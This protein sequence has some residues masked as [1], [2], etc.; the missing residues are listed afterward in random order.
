MGG[1]RKALIIANDTYEQDA[2]SNL[3]APASDAEALGR[4]LGN[5]QIGDF[6]VQVVQNEPRHVI[7]AQIEDLFS[8]SRPDDVLLMHFSGHGLKSESGDLFFA[9]C[10]TRPNRLRATAVSAD[11]VQQCMR[12]SRSRSIVLLLDCCYAGAFTQGVRARAAGAVNVF[13]S[14]PQAGG[15]GRAVITASNAIEYAFEGDRLA[16]DQHGRPS[17]FTGALVEGLAT[18]DADQDEDGWVSLNE[19]YDYV[20]DKVRDQNPQQTPSRQ[21]ELEGE[22]YL[23]RSQRRRIHPAAI[24]PE[25][26]AALTDAN[27]FARLGAVGE[28]RVRLASDNL[29]VA[30]GAYEALAE[31][32]RTDIRF[33]ADPAAKALSEASVQPA[34]TELHFGRAEHGSAPPHQIVHLLGPPIARACAP[35]PSHD[36]IRVDQVAEGLDI[37][38]DT[39]AT[40]TLHGSLDLKGPTGEAVI[41]I[42]AEIVSAPPEPA[43][44]RLSPTGR[45][46]VPDAGALQPEAPHSENAPLATAP[47]APPTAPSS[48]P[49]PIRRGVAF[50]GAGI[51][52]LAGVAWL[53]SV[54]LAD[55]KGDS[56][57]YLFFIQ[58]SNVVPIAV[59]LIALLRIN[60]LVILGLLQGMWWIAASALIGDPVNA[61]V[62][63]MSGDTGRALT[64]D[65]VGIIGDV[66]GVCAVILLVISWNQAAG[67]RHAWKFRM[68]PVMLVCGVGL[69]QI[70]QFIF[71]YTD[72]YS[73]TNTA[74]YIAAILVGLA[75]AWYATRLRAS[76]LGGALVLG[77]VTTTALSLIAD[78][79]TSSWSIGYLFAVFSCVLLATVVILTIIYM[80]GPSEP[81]PGPAPGDGSS[82]R[83]AQLSRSAGGGEGDALG[84]GDGAD[85][86]SGSP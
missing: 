41:A 66:L 26:Q 5:P 84:P 46:D 11:F 58:A 30:V 1:Q 9:A 72:Y 18:G 16:D 2:L 45:Q 81:D 4:V 7:E 43:S 55:T 86:S 32:A 52:L 62:D 10:N 12:D 44:P 20:F 54:A 56:L 38:I 63:H 33:V 21:V 35:R 31:R 76:T 59:A 25:L 8:D 60:R 28:L 47:P 69:S 74:N 64:G 50:A 85:T 71:Y 68:L 79:T 48:G 70:A 77:W 53:I 14:F 51:A 39:T 40:G 27:M 22:L 65:L 3:L 73:A 61:S 17:V 37:S 78:M 6:A 67:R 23:A 29:P 34:K 42:E 75:L 36:W 80:R 49:P 57:A 19:L 15:R 82:Q 13:D 24:P 83:R